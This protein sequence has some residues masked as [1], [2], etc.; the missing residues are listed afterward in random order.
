MDVHMAR[1]PIFDRNK[2]VFGYELLFRD[3]IQ[4]CFPK[5]DSNVATCSVL[6]HGF[7]ALDFEK[8]FQQKKLFINFPDDLLLNRS[9]LLFPKDHLVV[10]VL[11]TVDI[12]DALADALQD[13]ASQGYMIALDDFIDTPQWNRFFPWIGIIKIDI[14]TM[15]LDR[16]PE[17]RSRIGP[18]PIR[19]LAEKVET[20]EEFQQTLDLGFD[21]FQGYFFC[22]PET[23]RTRDIA[24]LRLPLIQLMAE[25]ARDEIRFEE[26]D[27]I[28]A[29]DVNISYK[30]LRYINSA[31]FFRGKEISS[32]RQALLRLGDAGIRRFIPI[33]AMSHVATGKPNELI[34]T[35]VIRAKFCEML[36]SELA[37]SGLLAKREIP[38]WFLMGLFSVIDGI[39]DEPMQTVLSRIAL[40]STIRDALLGK[41]GAMSNGLSLI[42]AYEAGAWNETFDLASRLGIALDDLPRLYWDAVSWADEFTGQLR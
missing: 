1:Q 30:L 23:I 17:L 11:E 14:R 41:K 18:Y 40:S 34:R 36:A 19:L 26:V 4:A 33:V 12:T 20:T 32:I 15:P 6:N 2:S 21:Y 10:E 38:E 37:G 29:H 16:I 39:M 42:K 5:V 8:V 31:Y 24:P 7:L 13:L 9:P 22:K 25:I 35:G 28:V 27:R 3:G